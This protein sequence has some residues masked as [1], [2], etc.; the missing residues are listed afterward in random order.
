[1]RLPRRLV[2]LRRMLSVSRDFFSLPL[3]EKAAFG[4]EHSAHFRGW[5][6]MRNERDWREQLHLGRECPSTASAIEAGE[7]PAF[8]RLEGPNLWPA[9]A[10]WREAVMTYIDVATGLGELILSRIAGLLRVDPTSFGNTKSDG[11]LVAKIIA[12]HPQTSEQALRSGVAAHVD[13]SW[14]TINLQDSV[15][16][17]VRRPDGRWGPVDVLSDAVWVHVGELLE[18]ATAGR[19]LATPHRVLNPSAETTRLS[20]PVFVN[21]PLDGIVPVFTA[22]AAHDSLSPH[23]R[24]RG[25]SEEHIHRVLSRRS[26]YRPFTFG[27]AEWRRKGKGVWCC[28]CCPSPPEDLSEPHSPRSSG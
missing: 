16:L 25:E 15:G 21:P 13:F 8:R 3:E 18:H 2:V 27:P 14:L 10:A 5:S 26:G 4:I 12:Y 22:A 9:D 1:M 17:E 20:I 24:L 28:A 23:D 6:E 11:Y 7:M 19:Y